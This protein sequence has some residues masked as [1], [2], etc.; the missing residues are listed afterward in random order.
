[1][2]QRRI[3]DFGSLLTQE[4]TKTLATSLFTPGIYGGM[5]PVIISGTQ[6]QFQLG[7]YLLPNG[8]LVG[9]DSNVAITIPTPPGPQDYTVIVDH[10]DIQATG[11]SPA[12]YSL[13]DG[14][15]D[16]EGDPNPNSLALLWIRHTGGGPLTAEMLSRPPIL[17]AGTLLSAI[18][19]GFMPAP[20]VR[21]C[22]EVKGANILVTSQ[23]HS[24][25]FGTGAIL[26]ATGAT[27]VGQIDVTGLTGMSIDDVGR[28]M[29]L[30]AGAGPNNGWF[31]ITAYV[32]ANSVRITDN[33]TAPGSEGSLA[34]DVREPEQLG[35]QII[36]TAVTGL[37]TY[38][39]RLPLPP[40]PQ[41]KSIEVYADLASLATI[42][43]D[44]APY[45]IH[46]AD[47]S[48]L[49]S[50][51]NKITGPLVGLDPGSS[52]VGT[53]TLGNYDESNAPTSIGV[54]IE[55]PAQTSC[56]FIRGFNL[57]GD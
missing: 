24:P 26:S 37:Q 27:T 35:V 14:I 41:P 57:I 56:V 51:P 44:T 45:L 39:F 33:G 53:F 21:A 20:F 42:S 46:A 16:R 9:E 25:N 4:R 52:P 7:T 8:V 11:G 34:W 23:S 15:R 28:F 3:Y 12:L 17:Q 32:S 43:L 18:E 13:V 22:D 10:D 36:N 38:Q 30:S 6:L 50:T 31:E 1:M 2:V 29:L 40:R 5:E 19:D 47:R 55:V 54:T 48:P 49:S